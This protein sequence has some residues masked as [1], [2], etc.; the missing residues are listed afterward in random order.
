MKKLAI[1]YSNFISDARVK[2]PSSMPNLETLVIS[3]LSEVFSLQDR[4]FF[5]SD[6]Y[7]LHCSYLV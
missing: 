7:R 1:D 3:S 5:A 6:I 4:V 2:L